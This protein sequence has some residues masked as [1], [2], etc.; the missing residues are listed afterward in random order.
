MSRFTKIQASQDIKKGNK[1]IAKKGTKGM[2]LHFE[3]EL[4][5]IRFSTGIMVTIPSNYLSIL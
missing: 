5:Y 2:I 4:P 3:N 1:L